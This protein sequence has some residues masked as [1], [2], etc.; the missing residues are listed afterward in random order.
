MLHFVLIMFSR[1]N[2]YINA[3]YHDTSQS[4]PILKISQEIGALLKPA[5]SFQ[6][7][8]INANATTLNMARAIPQLIKNCVRGRKL[9]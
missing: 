3:R 6:A 1:I 7:N 5:K 2:F 4:Y 9:S 8:E